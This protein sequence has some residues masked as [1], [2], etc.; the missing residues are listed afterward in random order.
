AA[1]Q[2]V[3]TKTPAVDKGPQNRAAGVALDDGARLAQPHAAATHGA[4]GEFVPHESVQ[5]EAADDHV[6]TV[7]TW[8]QGRVKGLTH[9]GFDERQRAP[10]Q[11]GRKRA[12][13][14]DMPVS[15]KALS[16]DGNG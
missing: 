3:G 16:R 8:V 6:A 11:A 5:I 4:D 14:G 7:L 2:D 15:F 1:D 9:L 13:P 10:R 12:G